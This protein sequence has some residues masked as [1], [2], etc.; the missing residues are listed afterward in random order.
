M[1]KL[2]LAFFSAAA[3]LLASPALATDEQAAPPASTPAPSCEAPEIA[4]QGCCSWHQ[5]VCGCSGTR[6]L[7]CDGTLS[8]SCK[9][10]SDD[11]PPEDEPSTS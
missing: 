10:H 11:R 1:K 9:C 3:L 6:V 5:G 2:A 7:C 4:Q 8:P